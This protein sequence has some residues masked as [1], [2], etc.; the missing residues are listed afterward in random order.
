MPLA[1]A[2]QRDDAASHDVVLSRSTLMTVRRV[3]HALREGWMLEERLASAAR[4]AADDAHR[5]RGG[6]AAMLVALKHEWAAL[7]EVRRLPSLDTRDVLARL[8]TLSICAYYSRAPFARRAGRPT[9][10]TDRGHAHTAA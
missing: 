7:E 1:A 9:E 10:H 3:L 8:V 6:A 4:M 5:S 2:E